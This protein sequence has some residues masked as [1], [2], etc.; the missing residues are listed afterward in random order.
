MI[1]VLLV[2]Y[3][4]ADSI[5]DIVTSY[6][7]EICSKLSAELIVAEDGSNDGTKEILISLKDEL[8]IVLLSANKRKGY[9][10]GVND[11]LRKCKGDWVFF[12]DSDGQYLPSDFWK[13][14][15]QRDGNNMIIGAKMHRREAVHRTILA[16]GFHK[17][18]NRNFRL[19]LHD[20]DCGF[21]LIRK[22]VIQSIIDEVRFL[23][24][25]YW[26]EFT[27]RAC[28][29]GFKI[30]E[31]PISHRARIHGE[32]HIYKNSKIPMIILKQLKGLT[33]LYSEVKPDH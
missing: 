5:R 10:N 23:E 33:Y 32:T 30:C 11:G 12:S 18:L 15:E 7:K 13:L 29:K 6:Y 16:R 2:A 20:A 31:V 25:S 28:L 17:I 3:N 19:S 1:S 14:W 8:P 24:Y 9:A 4:E 27:I 22:D 26:A 21:R